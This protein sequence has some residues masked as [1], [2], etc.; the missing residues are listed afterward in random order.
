MESDGCSYRWKMKRRET[1]LKKI[2]FFMT[3]CIIS[4]VKFVLV[5][6]YRFPTYNVN[7]FL[8]DF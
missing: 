2:E 4:S 7:I 1:K 5:G 8:T 3:N 6:L